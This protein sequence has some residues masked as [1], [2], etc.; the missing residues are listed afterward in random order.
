MMFLSSE[1]AGLGFTLLSRGYNIF[2][3]RQERK[4]QKAYI[5]LE[6]ESIKQQ[7][8][9]Q[10][11]IN[12]GELRENLS[13]VIALS[14]ARGGTGGSQLFQFGGKAFANYVQEEKSL[15]SKERRALLGTSLKNAESSAKNQAN[16]FGNVIQAGIDV[17]DTINFNKLVS[18]MNL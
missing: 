6:K 9:E 1:G 7:A 8:L 4:L 12:T 11:I 18:S 14:G 15:A 16:L 5:D 10:S 2:S 13:S 3:S 17:S